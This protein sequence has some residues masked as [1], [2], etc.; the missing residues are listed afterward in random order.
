MLLIGLILF[1][2]AFTSFCE[3]QSAL[4]SLKVLYYQHGANDLELL[5]DIASEES[6]PDSV[7]KYSELLITGAL[8]SSNFKGCVNGYLQKGNALSR[9]GL[10]DKALEAYFIAIDYAQKADNQDGKAK[11]F[12]AIGNIYSEY[13][14]SRNANRYYNKGIEILRTGSDSLELAKAI[15][16]TGD[17]YYYDNKLDSALLYTQEADAIFLKLNSQHFHAYCIGNLGMI[18]ARN[19][20]DDLALNAINEAI[21]ILEQYEDFYPMAVYLISV[22]DIY[23]ANA[24]KQTALKYALRSLE[25]AQRHSLNEQV[26]EANLKLSEIYEGLG[27]SDEAL[28]H[29]KEYILFRDSV[30]NIATVQQMANLRADFEVSQKQTEVDLLTEQKKNQQIIT[31]TIVI[32]LGLTLVI[33]FILIWYYKAISKEKDRSES[34]LLNILPEE[35]AQE[36]KDTGKADARDFDMVSILFTDFKGFTEQSAK[37]SA[38]ELVQE[39][40]HC[41][42]AFDGIM[43]KYDVEKIKTIGDAYMA[44]GGLPV[45]TDIS[46]KNTVLAA[47]EMQAFI[48]THKAENDAANKP[49]FEMRVGI[50]T[51]PVV[52]GIVGVK[53][54]QYDI[55]GD[56]VNT[57]SRIES[58]G[59]VGKVNISDSTYKLVKDKFTCTHRGKIQ[60]KGKGEIDM[61]FVE[62]RI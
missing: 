49:A 52:A 22:A 48:S 55:W 8:A 44:A 38:A 18:Y 20:D 56:T 43:E 27:Y 34:L 59:E 4:D 12:I 60:A 15:F 29:Y 57:A 47:L 33:L 26:S 13:D 41:F 16:N 32:I 37:L 5:N 31:T 45:P 36:L 54:F 40:N 30:N 3:E 14:D 53:K 51:G 39:I 28:L 25:L 24:D 21:T 42:E 23:L 6:N 9:K 2:T 61:Y 35:I 58:N 50:H 46:V 10:L 7:L 1:A 11:V 17:G 62:G 19:G